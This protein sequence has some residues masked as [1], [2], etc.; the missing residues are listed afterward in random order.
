MCEIH[1]HE[2][3]SFSQTLST[4]ECNGGLSKSVFFSWTIGIRDGETAVCSDLSATG[5]HFHIPLNH[6]IEAI[7]ASL[8]SHYTS[9]CRSFIFMLA[10]LVPITVLLSSLITAA[11]VLVLTGWDLIFDRIPTSLIPIFELKINLS[12]V[13]VSGPDKLQM[14]LNGSINTVWSSHVIPANFRVKTCSEQISDLRWNWK[15][16]WTTISSN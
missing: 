3:Y 7:K 4:F 14:I 10:S 1:C 12:T 16:R 15:D 8:A 2:S 9:T 13:N 5:I 6:K 11:F